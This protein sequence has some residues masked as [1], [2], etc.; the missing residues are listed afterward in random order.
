M[1]STT[2]L[3]VAPATAPQPAARSIVRFTGDGLSGILRCLFCSADGLPLQ[4]PNLQQPAQLIDVTFNP[5]SLGSVWGE[6][7]VAVLFWPGPAGPLGA[8]VAEVQLPGSAPLQAAFVQ[9]ACRLGARLAR[10]GEFS[11]RSFLAGKI[12]LLQ[13]EAVVAVI[14]ARTPHEL[15][16]A[17]DRMAGGV[18]RSVEELRE[19]LLDLVA[20][21][22]AAIDF[23]DDLAPDAVPVPDT[24]QDAITPKIRHVCRQLDRVTHHLAGR[25][26]GGQGAL[27][28]VVLAGA[29]N[30]GKSSLFNYLVGRDAA[31]VENASGTTRDWIAGE[32]RDSAGIVSCL[33]VDLAGIGGLHESGDCL[34]AEREVSAA[35]DRVAREEI[36]RADVIVACH[37]ID[38]D[39]LTAVADSTTAECIHVI[40]RVDQRQSEKKM[41][42]S[43]ECIPTSVKTGVGIEKLRQRILETVSSLDRATPATIR[44][45]VGL[46][47]A[48]ESLVQAEKSMTGCDGLPP[49]EALLAVLLRHA[50]DSLGE[51]TGAVVGTD[52]LDRVF[53]RHCIGK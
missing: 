46:E 22:E 35:A 20:D 9:E 48:R 23:S 33:L 39:P 49:D 44:L 1:D 37:D 52:I 47:S 32:L 53:S 41:A 6:L 16:Q 4:L 43:E 8:A 14:D 31:L 24:T 45:R 21:I 25:D 42:G 13:A 29:P 19:Y 30:I 51:V 27:P 5:E 2:D 50:I 38:S 36:Q 7:P 18:G 11:L 26:S 40:T 34:V 12:D 17:L 15:S 10:G 28:R 3:I